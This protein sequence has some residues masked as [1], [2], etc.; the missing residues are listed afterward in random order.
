MRHHWKWAAV[1]AIAT[2]P[3]RGGGPPALLTYAPT[4]SAPP[5]QSKLTEVP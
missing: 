3:R 5:S 1:E 2:Q 4:T